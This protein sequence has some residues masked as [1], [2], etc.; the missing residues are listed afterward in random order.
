MHQQFASPE[1][2]KKSPANLF[3]GT[4]VGEPPMNVFPATATISDSEVSLLLSDDVTLQYPAAEF[5]AELRTRLSEL[6]DI[7]VGVRPYAVQLRETGSPATVVANQWLG[8]QSHIAANFA[9]GSSGAR[10]ERI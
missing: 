9:G 10:D 3:T 4:F 6:K 5:S 8:D 1:D 2:I 7:V